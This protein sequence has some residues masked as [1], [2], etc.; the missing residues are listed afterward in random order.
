[1]SYPQHV[2]KLIRSVPWRGSTVR[3]VGVHTFAELR[4]KCVGGTAKHC[5]GCCR[6]IA[7]GDTYPNYVHV[8]PA[9]TEPAF[10]VTHPSGA[11]AFLR[12]A[13]ASDDK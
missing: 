5:L 8:F 3:E 10:E 4:I 6:G 13:V 9:R 1:M 7:R 12:Q 11:V 2:L